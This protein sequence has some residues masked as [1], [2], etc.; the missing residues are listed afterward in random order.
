[1]SCSACHVSWLTHDSALWS[2]LGTAAHHAVVRNS[3]SAQTSCNAQ[4]VVALSFAKT[5][6]GCRLLVCVLCATFHDAMCELACN[7]TSQ[8]RESTCAVRKV[9]W[10]GDG[11]SNYSRVRVHMP[12]KVQPISIAS[13]RFL[14][15]GRI[16]HASKPTVRVTLASLQPYFDF[17]CTA[18]S[19][20]RTQALVLQQLLSRSQPPLRLP[21]LQT[22]CLC[23]PWWHCHQPWP[24]GVSRPGDIR[25]PVASQVRA[26]SR[27]SA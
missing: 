21:C 5:S 3:R 16:L 26:S 22:L 19:A 13:A 11:D 1:M 7:L 23:T 24:R 14:R 10:Y 18:H 6:T 12:F 2:T 4:R 25:S 17:V 20:A 27:G 9:A 15:E 8:T